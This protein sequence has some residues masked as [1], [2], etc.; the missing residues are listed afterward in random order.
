MDKPRRNHLRNQVFFKGAIPAPEASGRYIFSF[1]KK[2]EE[3]D[4]ASI[5]AR[6]FEIGY[7]LVIHL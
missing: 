1:F 6:A 7:T 4:A 5:W 3:K 2:K